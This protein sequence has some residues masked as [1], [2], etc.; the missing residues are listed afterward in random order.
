MRAAG[1]ARSQAA[2]NQ[3]LYELDEIGRGLGFGGCHVLVD[4]VTKAA[5]RRREHMWRELDQRGVGL[6]FF[7][8]E[9]E[10]VDE[11]MRIGYGC[12]ALLWSPAQLAEMCSYRLR[13]LSDSPV[14][15]TAEDL[16]NGIFTADG[17]SQLCANAPAPRPLFHV[18]SYLISGPASSEHIQPIGGEKVEAILAQQRSYAAGSPVN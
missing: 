18:L 2:A 5:W 12:S 13:Q 15:F 17:W 6:T 14:E 8:A 10:T 16:A 9:N 4:D 1:H 3:W 7:T 11:L